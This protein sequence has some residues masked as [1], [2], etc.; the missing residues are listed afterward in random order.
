M[1]WLL[2]LL[3]LIVVALTPTVLE[4]KL[5]TRVVVGFFPVQAARP[6]RLDPEDEAYTTLEA[7]RNPL[8]WAE[9]L[10]TSPEAGQFVTMWS[11]KKVPALAHRVANA[12]LL[13]GEEQNLQLVNP[14]PYVLELRLKGL[15]YEVG[16]PVCLGLLDFLSQKASE[17]R[18]SL[19]SA[20]TRGEAYHLAQ[21]RLS[22][23]EGQM[24]QANLN[25]QAL[26]LA[27]ARYQTEFQQMLSLRAGNERW[28]CQVS[29]SVPQWCVLQPPEPLHSPLPRGVKALSILVLCAAGL[30]LVKAPGGG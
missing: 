30:A 24:T 5:G 16:K 29:A 14:A 6:D 12:A 18:E 21:E 15:D 17:E 2:G 13:L 20:S 27:A 11:G 3:W 9:K 10:L 1:R 19:V 28:A 8:A 4:G 23:S 25:S 7:W 26:E 22:L